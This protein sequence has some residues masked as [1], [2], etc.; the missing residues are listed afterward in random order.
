MQALSITLLKEV[1][2]I[3]LSLTTITM[4]L[5]TQRFCSDIP[6]PWAGNEDSINV[7]LYTG[8]AEPVF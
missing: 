4:V 7:I 8:I 2:S 3:Y 1:K 6:S 5:I